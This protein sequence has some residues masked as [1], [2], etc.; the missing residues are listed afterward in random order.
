MAHTNGT[1][2]DYKGLLDNLRR[3]VAGYGIAGT[4]AY[5]GTGNGTMTGVDCHP[6]TLTETWTVTCTTAVQDGGVFSVVGS[7][8]GAKADATVGTPYDNGFIAFTINDGSTDFVVDDVFTADVTQGA[9]SAAS[10][11]WLEKRWTTGDQNELVLQG[12][13]DDGQQ[14]ILV[15]IQTYYNVASDYY[16]WKLQGYTGYQSDALF[17]AQ[18]GAIPVASFTPPKLA[19]WNAEM[20][21][22]LTADG[23]HI[24]LSVKVSTV[25]ESMYL[26]F[27]DAMGTPGQYPYPLVIAGSTT[28]YTSERWSSQAYDVGS[29]NDP[30]EAYAGA[31]S[32]RRCPFLLRLPSGN[33]QPFY[34]WNAGS[35]NA[36]FNVWP[37][38]RIAYMTPGAASQRESLDGSVP[39]MALLLT[40]QTNHNVYGALRTA[41][42]MPG[43]G[44]SSENTISVGTDNYWVFQD[45]FR[46]G[47]TN[48][49]AMKQ[50]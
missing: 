17:D 47:A 25:Y 49:W 23:S 11:A 33:W 18:P 35:A 44:Q 13:G 22:W 20:P 41:F 31:G 21:Y 12:P 38:G 36:V 9:M 15:G 29:F 28:G 24:V 3:F 10:M 46:T 5:T 42:W 32:P 1:A 4:P 16:N 50:G 6:A 30:H 39:L 8:S 7:A 19:L 37:Y 34:N 40:D 45:T 2:T 48:Y 14:Q 27:A 26:G 43:F